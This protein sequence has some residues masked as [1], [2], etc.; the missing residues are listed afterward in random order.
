MKLR[1]GK[2]LSSELSK[3]SMELRSGKVLSVEESITIPAPVKLE[4][5]KAVDT[6]KYLLKDD[7]DFL[8]KI[9]EQCFLLGK[10]VYYNDIR[11]LV[12]EK[13]PDTHQG[14]RDH[15]LFYTLYDLETLIF[16]RH[17]LI[18]QELEKLPIETDDIEGWDKV[19]H[20][21]RTE[22]EKEVISSVFG[23]SITEELS[24]NVMGELEDSFDNTD[25]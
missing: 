23:G 19:K 10:D 7:L 2:T 3:D 25:V 15:L 6:L 21:L 12:E 4:L 24:V 8:K 18:I 9:V 14:G 17:S 16:G 13:Y 20:S 1:S 22:I 11:K 5:K